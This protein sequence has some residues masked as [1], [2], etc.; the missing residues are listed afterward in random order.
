MSRAM[1][2]AP[3]PEAVEIGADILA[4][5][6]NAI[7]AA[8]ACAFAQGVADNLMCG[9]G[10]FGFA[11]VYAPLRGV[12]TTYDFMSTAPASVRGDM[13][14]DLLEGETR[15]GFGFI[16][17]GRVNDIGYRSVAVPG[18]LKGYQAMH[19]GF[20]K[21]AWRDVVAPAIALAADGYTVTPFVRQYWV[22]PERMGRVEIIDRISHVPQARPLYFGADGEPHPVGARVRNPELAATL[23][24]I[25]RDGADSFFHGAIA[26]R[27]D[28]DF[29]AHDGL[30]S[31]RDLENYR[32]TERAPIRRAYRGWELAAAPP[33]ASGLMLLK[34]LGLLAH[35]DLAALGHNSAAYIRLLAEVMKRA[36]IDKER[37]IGDPDFMPIPLEPF[38]SPEL[39][40]AEAAAIKRGERAIVPRVAPKAVESAETTHLSVVDGEGNIVSMT[41]TLGMQ[42]GVI[43]PGLGFMYNAAMAMFD[44]RPGR[45][46]SLAP[47]KKRVSSMAPSILFKDGRPALVIGA[48]GG[49]N[50]PMGILQ[51][52][53]NVVDFGM[54]IGEAVDAPRMAAT[55]NV[56]DVSHRIPQ[57]VCEAL[58]RDG[59]DV[60]RSA[61]SYVVARPHAIRID[62][63]RLTGAADPAAGGMALAI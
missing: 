27:I 11:Q 55:G 9:I 62:G 58:R 24:I 36:Q 46:M 56:I 20:G 16:L 42:S 23:S 6:G 49:S 2:C 35:F 45:A 15:D 5:G 63:E 22:T 48:P 7:D 52:I 37:H 57:R 21:L 47:G 13:W 17:K 40:A 3:Q 26:D 32:V 14:A 19:A 4:R 60:L 10:G 38:T 8:V 50:I 34:M 54:P 29:R 25:A 41:H 61:H 1:I 39:L 31:R 33:P 44:P 53:L 59:Y 43:T 28:A 30:L 51:V 12:H 18:M